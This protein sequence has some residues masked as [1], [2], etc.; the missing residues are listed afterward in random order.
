VRDAQNRLD[1]LVISA[2]ANSVA[3][4]EEAGIGKADA[5]I[6]VTESDELNMIIYG[7]AA[8]IHPSILKIA[9]VRNDEYAKLSL[10][11]DRILGNAFSASI[12]LFIPTSP[13]L[14]PC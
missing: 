11:G 3:V 8:S 7:I 12:I 14:N 4:L 2:H 1:C 9:R 6:C 13:R 5:L 10:P